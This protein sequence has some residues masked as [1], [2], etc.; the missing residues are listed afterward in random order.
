MATKR[1]KSV[2]DASAQRLNVRV[3]VE[4]YERLLV[5]SIKGRVSPGELVTQLIEQHLRRWSMPGDIS[6][7]A[8]SRVSGSSAESVTDSIPPL[9]MA[10]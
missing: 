9:A 3:T 1:G 4:A 5:H 8:T 10:G 7:R 2:N 6:Q